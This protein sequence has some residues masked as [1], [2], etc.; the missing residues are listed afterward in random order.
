MNFVV[1]VI[2]TN[3]VILNVCL[4]PVSR[5]SAFCNACLPLPRRACPQTPDSHSGGLDAGNVYRLGSVG[6][7][8]QLCLWDMQVLDSDLLG[9][10]NGSFPQSNSLRQARRRGGL[11]CMLL[12]LLLMMMMMVRMM[13]CCADDDNDGNDAVLL[14]LLLLLMMVQYCC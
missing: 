13:V 12:L 2:V 6:Q 8:A 11:K 7:D 4:C 10:G 9:I 14:L 5:V 1:I 3:T